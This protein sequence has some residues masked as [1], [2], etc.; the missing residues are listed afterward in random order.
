MKSEVVEVTRI[1]SI[2]RM[3]GG[4]RWR[5]VWARD[6]GGGEGDVGRDVGVLRV[7]RHS[8]TETVVIL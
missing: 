2:L 4:M 7:Y 8:G 3:C 1:S 5:G 6:W